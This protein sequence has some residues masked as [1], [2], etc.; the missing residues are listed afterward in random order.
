MRRHPWW[1]GLLG[2]AVVVG[3]ARPAP[4]AT[5]ENLVEETWEEARIEDARV[6]FVHTVVQ[7]IQGGTDKRLRATAMLDLTL[8]R[9]GSIVRLRTEQGTEETAEGRVVAV[10]LRQG[11]EGSRQ[12]DLR[13]ELEE[14]QMHVI[15]DGGRLERRLGWPAGVVGWH[16]REHLFQKR[17]PASGSSFEFLRYEPVFNAVTTVRVQ[18]RGREEVA[19]PGGTKSLLR[20]EMTPDRLEAP[21]IKVQPPGCTWWLDGDLLPVRRTFELEGLGTVVL[22]RSTRQAALAPATPGAAGDI[23]AKTLIPV[24]RRISRPYATRSAVYRITLR[25]D[26]D[27]EAAFADDAHQELRRLDRD[28]FEVRVHPASSPVRQSDAGPPPADCLAS[29][30]YIDSDAEVFRTLTARAVGDE[31]AP[32][33][34]ARRIERWVKQQMRVDNAAPLVC[35]S[36]SARE[37]RGDCRHYS[38]LTAALCRASGIPARTAIGLLY[39]E[40]SGRPQMGF[41]MWTEVWIDGQWL[42]LDATLGHGHVDAAHVKISDHS[43]K[44]TQSLTPLLPVQRVLGKIRIE[45]VRVEEED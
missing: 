12:L 39:V 1:T 21:G 8:R 10:F 23:G 16:S 4:A 40:R 24:D 15:V 5:D 45:V 31:T 42:G 35:A 19:L 43:W 32:W 13:G 33:K 29:C 7:E 41:H 20:V 28:H 27:R 38:L 17:R 30:H 22:T 18:V 2:M 36:V 44:E 37:L 3:C 34:K 6:G 14:G 25:D 26:G 9:H 11:Q